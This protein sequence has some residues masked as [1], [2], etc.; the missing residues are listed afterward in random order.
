[1]SSDTIFLTETRFHLDGTP[2]N[3]NLLFVPDA[4]S[5]P[6]AAKDAD[7]TAQERVAIRRRSRSL[8]P[9]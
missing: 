5:I 8:K 9:P 2:T 7:V 1:M 3:W 4:Y 6:Y